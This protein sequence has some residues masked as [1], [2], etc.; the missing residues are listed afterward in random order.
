MELQVTFESDKPSG[1]GGRVQIEDTT[2]SLFP[3]I[4]SH[5]CENFQ[6]KTWTSEK[7]F[8]HDDSFLHGFG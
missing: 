1:Q 3:N 2:V 7:I 4:P 8:S 6:I 5:T